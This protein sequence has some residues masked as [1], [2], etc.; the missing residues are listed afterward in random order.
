M[1]EINYACVQY[2][3]DK[4]KYY[5]EKTTVIFYKKKD[6]NHITPQNYSDYDPKHK[7]FILYK[8]SKKNPESSCDTTHDNDNSEFY[9]AYIICLG[10]SETD[11][12]NRASN[13]PKR[14]IFPKKLTSSDSFDDPDESKEDLKPKTG[15]IISTIVQK[16]N[17]ERTLQKY[18]QQTLLNNRRN[19]SFSELKENN[20]KDEQETNPKKI[21]NMNPEVCLIRCTAPHSVEKNDHTMK[22]YENHE[23]SPKMPLSTSTPKTCPTEI[24]HTSQKKSVQQ[25]SDNINK[26]SPSVVRKSFGFSESRSPRTSP[27]QSSRSR[28]LTSRS[29]GLRLQTPPSARSGVAHSRTPPRAD[30]GRSR[31]QSQGRSCS[32]DFHARSRRSPSRLRSQS[33][34]SHSKVSPSR[35][36]PRVPTSE[37]G[38]PALSG[39][40]S[41]LSATSP[42]LSGAPSARSRASNLRTPPREDAGRCRSRSQRR[43]RS[44][45]SYERSPRR[46][47]H[48]S[49][50]SRSSLS[51]SQISRSQ[52]LPRVLRSETPSPVLSGAP[53]ALSGAPP[54]ISEAPPAL[55]GAPSARSRASNSRIPPREDAGRSRSQSQRRSHSGNSYDRSPRRSPHRSSPSRSSLSRSQISRS[56]RPPRVL[57]SETPSPALSGA[58]SARSRASNSRTPPREDAGPSRSRSQRRSRSGNSYER[59]P[60]RSPHRSPALPGASNLRPPS[61]ADSRLSR[62]RLQR[63]SCSG[64]SHAWSRRSPSPSSRSRISRLQVSRP[65]LRSRSNSRPSRSRSR[66]RSRSGVSR[67]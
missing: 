50:P 53:P 16:A 48:R 20:G 14:F 33:R 8:N 59:S 51:R 30:A 1:S 29:Q 21:A 42:A 62:S 37:T 15:K 9:Q 26:S 58:P 40:P 22:D 4:V 61:R 45:N 32:E 63:P 25:K 64:D 49:S 54:A 18:K 11:A 6:K 17:T 44:G 60:R 24:A 34:M 57:R 52:R 55:S 10:V 19:L 13:K 43:S 5:Y 67:A 41:A 35:T 27:S 47:P 39:A 2:L 28:S 66:H 31:S 12:R 56:R 23:F 46:S 36:P 65:R 7:Y 38:P 3:D